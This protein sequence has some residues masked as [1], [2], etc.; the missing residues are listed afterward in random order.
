MPGISACIV[1]YGGYEEAVHAA[2]SVLEH[3]SARPLKLYMVDNASPDGTGEQLS[4]TE[5][6]PNVQVICLPKNVGFGSG[7]NTVLPMLDSDYHFVLNPDILVEYDVLSEMCDWMDAHPDV[8][9]ATPKLYFPDGRV[10]VLPKR[11]PN[12]LG[13]LAR[14]GFDSLK[15]YGDRYAMLDKDLSKTTDIEF[16]TGSF[17]CIRTDVFREMGG[18]DEGYFMYVEDADITQKALQHGRVC[19]VP[20]FRAIHAWHRSPSKHLGQAWLQF[21]SMGRYFRKWGFALK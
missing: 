11:R 14:Q 17:F 13:L 2:S 18:F 21:K 15:K 5:F 9:M 10:Q 12:V 16:C 6:A 20:Q 19:F 7:H 8:V 1:T 3:T 4:R